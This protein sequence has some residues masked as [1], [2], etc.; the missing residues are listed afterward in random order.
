MTYFPGLNNGG[1]DFVPQI[2]NSTADLTPSG[3]GQAAINTSL[4][5]HNYSGAA[6]TYTVSAAT[7]PSFRVTD[8]FGGAGGANLIVSGAANVYFRANGAATATIS[9][10]YGSNQFV[11]ISGTSAS[12]V[13]AKY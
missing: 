7:P 9:T 6:T 8:M 3:T 4:N 11:L 10:A 2:F 12:G 5:Y 13:W 1:N